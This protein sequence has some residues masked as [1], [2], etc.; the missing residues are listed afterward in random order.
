MS[1]N[2]DK[3]FEVVTTRL[4]KAPNKTLAQKQLK[5]SILA[6]DTYVEQTTAALAQVNWGIES[7]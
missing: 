5:K 1:S 4:V 3:Y 6:E 7:K 2:K